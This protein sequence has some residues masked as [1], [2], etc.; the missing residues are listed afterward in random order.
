[1]L[2]RLMCEDKD[3][4]FHYPVDLDI[5]PHYS[6]IIENPMDFGTIKRQLTTSLDTCKYETVG[7]FVSDVRLTLQ[8][9]LQYNAP[10]S[11]IAWLA[12][13]LG[14]TFERLLACWVLAPPNTLPPYSQLGREKFICQLSGRK[15]SEQDAVE[16]LV[17]CGTCGAAFH[18]S[19]LDPSMATKVKSRDWWCQYCSAGE[20]APP[21]S[22]TKNIARKHST[23]SAVCG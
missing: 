11:D 22:I 21:I 9:C 18:K 15:F 16:Q 19:I 8:N 3:R 10:Q 1:M 6:E 7:A 17:V 4:I 12:N 5:A 20:I 14:L 23:A 13:R 2:L